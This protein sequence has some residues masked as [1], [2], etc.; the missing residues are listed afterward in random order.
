MKLRKQ[1]LALSL[2]VGF[3]WIG[4]NAFAAA[5]NPTI[6]VNA[7]AATVCKFTTTASTVNLTVDPTASTTV[8]GTDNVL[9]RCTNGT[10]PTFLLTSSST[11]S[12][13]GGNLL[14]GAET[15]PYTFSSISGG[16]GSGLGSGNDKTLAVT[17][18][19]DQTAAANVTPGTYT[20][21]IIV[22][23]NP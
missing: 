10:S 5:P 14:Q 2:A 19:V 4:G 11:S 9:Y 15:I 21:T 6:T 18:G 20:D 12:T 1:V 3:A 23:V 22:S 7:S 8:T 16:A 13:S 17:V